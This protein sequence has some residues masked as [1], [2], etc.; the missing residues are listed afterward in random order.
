V[1]QSSV[2]PGQPGAD[3]ALSVAWAISSEKQPDAYES[4][5]ATISELYEVSGVA[6]GGRTGFR[7]QTTAWRF[8]AATFARGRSVHQTL[9]RRANEIRRSGLDHISIIINLTDT[10]GDCDGRETLAPAGSVQFRDLSRPSSSRADTIDTINLVTPRTSVPSWL[11]GR[12]IHGLVL[13]PDSPGGRLVASHLKTLAEVAG[14]LSEEEGGAAIEATFV[15]AERFLGQSGPVSPVHLESIHRTIRQRAVQVFDARAADPTLNV[16]EVALSI[17]VSRSAL[18]RAFGD[19]GGVQT[20]V[21]HRRLDRAYADLRVNGGGRLANVE[22]IGR[23]YGFGSRLRFD[24]AFR[25]RFGFPP[26][27]VAPVGFVGR[28]APLAANEDGYLDGAAHDIVVDWLRRGE[29]A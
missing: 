18:Y 20:Y 17:G 23:R 19:M 22:E 28:G 13:P 11:L 25:D 4:Y 12:K 21:L 14:D 27:E 26:T 15:I 5:R 24:R 9:S 29:A 10:V 3:K 7:S 8:G 1:S 2:R 16:N 6:D